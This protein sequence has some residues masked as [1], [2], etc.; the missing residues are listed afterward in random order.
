MHFIDKDINQCLDYLKFDK[1]N[2]HGEIKFAL[3]SKIGNPVIDV[4]VPE[5]IIREA[6]VFYL[7]D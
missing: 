7:N 6:F 4:L 3:L 1:K 2:S 5:E